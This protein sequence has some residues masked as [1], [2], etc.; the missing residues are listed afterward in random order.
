MSILWHPTLPSASCRK[1]NFGPNTERKRVAS[2]EKKGEG[3][4]GVSLFQDTCVHCFCSTESTQRLPCVQRWGFHFQGENVMLRNVMLSIRIWFQKWSE[5]E[6]KE[7]TLQ[8]KR[9]TLIVSFLH[10]FFLIIALWSICM[11]TAL[12]HHSTSRFVLG[13]PVMCCWPACPSSSHPQPQFPSSL[14]VFSWYSFLVER[15]Q[16]QAVYIPQLM[17]FSLADENNGPAHSH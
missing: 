14:S 7:G 17:E 16:T 8:M 4:V 3:H 12:G 2:G 6:S 15:P 5:M 13:E 1:K 9:H 10:S 11:T